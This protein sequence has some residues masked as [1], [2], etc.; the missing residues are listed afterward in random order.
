MFRIH[1]EV[2]INNILKYHNLHK[3]AM[4]MKQYHI[5]FILCLTINF[6]NA[7]SKASFKFDLHYAQT[8]RPEL[9]TYLTA[10]SD[11]MQVAEPLTI[12]SGFGFGVGF[13]LNTNKMEYEVGG[14]YTRMADEVGSEDDN[15]VYYK[16]GEI[17]Y[18][19]GVNYLP[20]KFFLLGGSF[21]INSANAKCNRTGLG[22]GDKY[23]ENLPATDFHIFRGYSVAVKGQSGFYINTNKDKGNRMQLTGYYIYGLS[24]YNFYTVS[25][26]R[27][28]G[29]TGEQKTSYT[30]AGIELAFLFRN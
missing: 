13:L 8:D 17:T 21:V 18:H 16:N 20:A 11:S 9:Q 23:L 14:G 7:Q 12:T 5:L 10:L 26:Q 3:G 1:H 6:A 24:D 19:F 29:Y 27:L 2:V 22:T 15:L 25:E 28:V 4:R 30:T